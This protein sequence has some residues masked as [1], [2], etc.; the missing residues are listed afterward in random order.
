MKNRALLLSIVLLAFT[1]TVY[2]D[3]CAKLTT[4]GDTY[5]GLLKVV[6]VQIDLYNSNVNRVR[7]EIQPLY[8]RVYDN[9]DVKAAYE[10][11]NKLGDFI[12]GLAAELERVEETYT[13]LD[14]LLWG[15]GAIKGQCREKANEL[16]D[17]YIEPLADDAATLMTKYD[18]L[19]EELER[20]NR[21]FSKF[22]VI[23]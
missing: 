11:E 5:N 15:R 6:N 17:D 20:V 7:S 16:T 23:G 18:D 2:A 22:C 4:L 3:G 12:E 10:L 1:S 19:I 13:D 14:L 21:E 9:D 8:T